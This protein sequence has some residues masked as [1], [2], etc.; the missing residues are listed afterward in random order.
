MR[1]LILDDDVSLSDILA[2]ALRSQR[3]LVETAIDGVTG[4]ELMEA[5]AYD[6]LVLDVLLPELNGIQFCQKLRRHGYQTPILMLT[7]RDTSQDKVLSL[8][9]GA[10]DYVVKPFD[11]PEL[12][13][14]VRAMLRR[15]SSEAPILQ[16][17]HLQFD[18]SACEVT[19]RGK[20]IKLTAK[21]YSL[22][23]LL[24]R[25][26][27]QVFSR[28]AILDHLWTFDDPPHEDAVKALVKRLRQKLVRVGGQ[29]DLIET[30]YGL[31]YR[32]KSLEGT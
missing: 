31:G 24:L 26:A 32:L 17:G 29:A 9:S 21:E 28:S 20:P 6:L 25:N 3:H 4:W 10:D 2:E 18:P 7:A 19:Y 15:G 11:L 27:K 13:A 16:W 8:D 5:T 23:E 14:R 1:I 12:M 30:V 22:L